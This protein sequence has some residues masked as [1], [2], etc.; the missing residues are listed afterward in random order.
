MIS[1]KLR[2][3]I[4]AKSHLMGSTPS[5]I[6][7]CIKAL[8]PSDPLTEVRGIPDKD[9]VPSMFMNYQSVFTLKPADGAVGTWEFD[10]SLLP[11]PVSFMYYKKVDSA[12]T[13][14]G[15]FNNSQLVGA[16]HPAKYAAFKAFA[17]R[18][19][20]AYMSVTAYQDGPDLSNQ[21]TIVVAQPPVKPG[22]LCPALVGD[23]FGY[24]LA[25]RKLAM[26]SA[27]DYPEFSSSQ[28]MPN[29]YFNKS[30]EGAYVPLKLTKTCQAWHS[31]EDELFYGSTASQPQ[32]PGCFV[33]PTVAGSPGFPITDVDRLWWHPDYT[34][35]GNPSSDMCNDTFAHISA[36]NLSV[37]TSFTFFVRCGFELQVSPT[38]VMAPQLKLSPQYDSKALRAYFAIARELKDAYPSDY[39]DL[40][41]IWEVISSAAKAVAPALNFIP[42]IGPVLAS[43]VPALAGVGDNIRAAY[44]NRNALSSG[45]VSRA[46]SA[47]DV[48]NTSRAVNALVQKKVSTMASMVKKKKKQIA[49]ARR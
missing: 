16:N 28:S 25:A 22:V 9:A 5:G 12:T 26:Y 14:V 48:A 39:N 20:L 42:G 3:I 40:G 21:G 23:S 17:Q 10:A 41:K 19:R 11:H 2:S 32:G 49:N 4:D 36:K 8:H 33:L 6:D 30:K 35:G 1:Q 7:W 38:S 18:W 34:H 31:E 43:A 44:V 13:E 37:A 15:N 45:G 47:S 29:A 46:A 24:A 27:E